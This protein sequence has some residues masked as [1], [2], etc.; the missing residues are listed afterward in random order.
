MALNWALMEPTAAISDEHKALGGRARLFRHIFEQ[1]PIGIAMTDL[2][3]TLI[4]AN[5]TFLRMLGYTADELRHLTVRDLTHPDDWN[6]EAR[7]F[8]A[9]LLPG[10][11]DT[12]AHIVKR[13]RRKD[14]IFVWVRLHACMIRDA[15]DR[16]IFGL[17]M[18]EDVTERKQ[19]DDRLASEKER[20]AVTLRSIGDAV[21][22]TDA[23]GHIQVL[24]T[25]AEAL[26]G[27]RQAEASGRYIGDILRFHEHR[28]SGGSGIRF[29]DVLAGRSRLDIAEPLLLLSRD[30]RQR[31][32]TGSASTIFDADSKPNGMVMAF[33]DVTDRAQVE[34]AQALT[35][36][37][38]SLG[39][40][41]GGIAHD[42]NNLLTAILGN[43]SLAASEQDRATVRDLLTAA[44]SATL[45]ARDLTVQLLTFAKGGIP[46]KEV[47]APASVIRESADMALH[48]SSSRV[49]Y[50]F[51]PSLW[52]VNMDPG[53]IGQVIRNLV[54]NADQA[55]P[56]GGR[57]VIRAENVMTDAP[58]AGAVPAGRYVKVSITDSGVGIPERHLEK[59]FDPY[60]TT[61][62]KGSGLG[63]A[64]S[65]S[66]VRHHGGHILVQSRAGIGTTFE[67][68]LPAFT[69]PVPS[70]PIAPEAVPKGP[71]RVLVMDDEEAIRQIASRI[72]ARN[73]FVVESASDGA[74]AI[75][76]FEDARRRGCPFD[77][78]ILDLTIRGGMG[79]QE[80]MRTLLELDPHVKA[81]VS[82]GYSNDPVMASHRQHGFRGVAA[83]PYQMDAF[84][85]T[86]RRVMAEP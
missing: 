82:S 73:G 17:G 40:L 12:Q 55:M 41:A 29:D 9:S 74:E 54:I 10:S 5:D 42:F 47:I 53:Q 20:L 15:E 77:V 30:G 2:D 76:L 44:E 71:G 16:P 28:A 46:I 85:E 22:A 4:E 52:A 38:E 56:G 34:A 75:R 79:G 26:T 70:L 31:L 18:V 58:V 23:A 1:S 64:T 6:S 27:W 72:L 43:I 68:Y 45:Q 57:I 25:V 60:F 19:A 51:A 78:V 35:D 50:G 24:N 13:Y 39:F 67:I 32:V 84:V 69:D 80:A 8:K 63:L 7:A 61:K 33:R 83:K 49:E 11:R 62:D 36:K 37:L 81:I 3:G 14:G 48:G 86:V 65:L 21:V 66:I 59:I